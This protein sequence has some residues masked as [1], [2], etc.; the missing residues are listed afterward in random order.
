MSTLRLGTRGSSLALWQADWMATL[1]RS[2]ADGPEVEIVRV[3]TLGDTDRSTRL[4]EMGSTGVFTKALEDALL[5]GRVDLAVHSLKDVETTLAPG[6][7]LGAFL[8]REDP[9]DALVTADGAT[10]LE[11]PDGA[12]VGTGS[13]RR[14]AWLLRARPDLEVVPVRGNVPTRVGKIQGEGLDAVVLAAAGLKRLGMEEH[15]SEFLDPER[16][17]PAP[18]QGIVAVQIR[19]DDPATQAHVGRVDDPVSRAA[20]EAER[21]FLAHLGGGCLLPVGAHGTLDR[22]RVH[23]RGALSSVEGASWLQEED[24]GAVGEAESVGRRLADRLLN[25]GGR[26]ILDGVRDRIQ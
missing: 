10:L 1:L 22:E 7:T 8:P 11:L 2:L 3:K 25:N 21:A 14:T 9:R 5:D 15:I 26:A 6:T 13:L 20:A 18:G 12:R 23:L 19:A 16:F 17:V 4:S 24:G